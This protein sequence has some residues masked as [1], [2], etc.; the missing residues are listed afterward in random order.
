MFQ[1]PA[2]RILSTRNCGRKWPPSPLRI[3]PR[4]ALRYFQSASG[5]RL[6]QTIVQLVQLEHSGRSTSRTAH[7]LDCALQALAEREGLV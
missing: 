2:G 4:G 1:T 5:Q 3:D 7:I 6:H